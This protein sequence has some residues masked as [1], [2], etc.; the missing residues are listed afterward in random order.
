MG[1][2]RKNKPAED[3]DVDDIDIDGIDDA[4]VPDA[5]GED[6]VDDALA[7][8]DDEPGDGGEITE[9]VQAL[10]AKVADL[11]SQV[12]QGND[13]QKTILK[14]L[15]ELN[16]TVLKAAETIS[17][18]EG[19]LNALASGATAEAKPKDAAA[20]VAAKSKP[21]AGAAENDPQLVATLQA[22]LKK[23]PSGTKMSAPVLAGKI[24][25]KI[26]DKFPKATV[27]A[28]VAVFKSLGVT[29]TLQDKSV[30]VIA[31]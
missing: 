14:A 31:K 8:L 10:T 25:A 13:N 15:Q 21:V 1:G 18:A 24:L 19:A 28:I 2:P 29:S 16:K 27:E 9:A 4:D 6:D 3:V 22:Y 23:L 12:K 5:P 26:Q 17:N 30:I 7:G 11:E 20:A